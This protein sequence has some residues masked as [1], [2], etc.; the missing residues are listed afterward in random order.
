MFSLD[1][2]YEWPYLR[3]RRVTRYREEMVIYNIFLC[4]T[5]EYVRKKCEKGESYAF[6]HGLF[7]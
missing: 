2:W 1:A 6:D 3:G 7:L 4:G 5:W